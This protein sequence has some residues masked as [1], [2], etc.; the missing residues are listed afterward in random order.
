VGMTLTIMERLAIGIGHRETRDGHCL[1]SKGIPAVLEVEES[2]SG[3][4]AGS[5]GSDSSDELGKSRLRR[6]ADSW[7]TIELLKLGFELSQAPV[8]KYLF[9]KNRLNVRRRWGG[10]TK[11][12]AEVCFLVVN[13]STLVWL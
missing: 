13:T 5:R 7:R 1:P 2:P 3:R 12:A 10:S 8:A 4:V 11:F 6:T 9:H